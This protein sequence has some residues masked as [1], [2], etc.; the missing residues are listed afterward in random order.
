MQQS[1]ES[2]GDYIVELRD[3]V[4]TCNFCDDKCV[5]K[6]LRDQLIEG[7]MDNNTV[8]DL[9]KIKELTLDV[10][11]NNAE[12]CKSA[13][14]NLVKVTGGA[15]I[16]AVKS[17]YKK[18]KGTPGSEC[19]KCGHTKHHQATE[20]PAKDKICKKCNKKGHFQ[21]MCRSGGRQ[22]STGD[23]K[24]NDQ[25]SGATLGRLSAIGAKEP[26]AAAMID[27][28]V[29]CE[30]WTSMCKVLPD[31]GA[32]ICAAGFDFFEGDQEAIER[33]GELECSTRSC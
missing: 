14:K 6:A 10:A 32:D 9:L 19:G 4:K 12:A 22:Q 25:A 16:Q 11:I 30:G 27:M 15:S 26:G 8:E 31:S 23:K 3:L 1:G 5:E 18:T 7:L 2:I 24:K 21:K 13:K 17:S 28:K 33:S 29:T 20:C